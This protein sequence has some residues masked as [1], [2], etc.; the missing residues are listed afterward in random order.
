[1][2]AQQIQVLWHEQNRN[3][4]AGEVLLIPDVPVRGDE[5]VERSFFSGMNQVTIVLVGPA[6]PIRGVH[7]M[8]GQEVA[9]L[10]WR[11]VVE[12]N[13]QAARGATGARLSS[14]RKF[15]ASAT[16]C[17]LTPSNWSRN[18]KTVMPRFRPAMSDSTGTRVPRN[19]QAPP[20][21]PGR[22]S[23][24]GHWDQSVTVKTYPFRSHFSTLN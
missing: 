5:Q 24:A 22:L 15:S 12:Q 18:S 17:R 20:S 9:N 11:A 7:L 13:L 1:M 4:P 6:Q 2:S 3:L 16:C 14:A 8:S 19:T 10:P 21:F 23:T